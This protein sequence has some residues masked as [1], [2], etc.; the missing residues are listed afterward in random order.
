MSVARTTRRVSVDDDRPAS[1]NYHAN[2]LVRGLVLLELLATGPDPMTLSEISEATGLPKST[3][4]R[5]LSVLNE[6]DYIV[7][8]DD[9][10]SYRLGHK[11]LRLSD[12][13]MSSLDLSVVADRY[14]GPLAVRTGQ[15][16]NLGMLD[17]DQVVHV[18]VHEPDR[19]I[20]YRASA[21][22][23]DHSYCTGLGKM[24]LSRLAPEQLATHLPAD[25]F[26]RFTDST[27]TTMDELT[28]ELRRTQR[29][30]YA[31]DD[32][33]RSVGLRCLAVPVQVDGE[34]LAAVS[35]SGPSGEFG[36]DR[37]QS[38]LERLMESAAE[39]A[40]D[41][42]TAAALRIVHDSLRPAEPAA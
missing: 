4:V 35:V 24:L 26:P 20:R 29:R 25:P 17:G 31:F 38:F 9:R 23:R 3:L 30:G 8:V 40:G 32:N 13:Y 22:V 11:V 10:P 7:R 19:P 12:A 16:A 37:Q 27:I 41:P 1:A 42:D 36:P 39:L 2:A 14:L 34:C 21:G 5:L 33:E 15:T 6:M 18:A 28:R